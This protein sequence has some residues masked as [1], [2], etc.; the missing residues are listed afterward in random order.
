M[1]LFIKEFA[2]KI[3][4]L[5]LEKNLSQQALAKQIGYKQPAVAK[6][7]AG[8]QIPIISVAIAYANFLNISID[9]LLGLEI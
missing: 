2:E 5:R 3:K 6:W 8:L 4:E 1:E 9:F 7:E